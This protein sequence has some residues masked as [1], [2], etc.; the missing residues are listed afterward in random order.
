MTISIYERPHCIRD[1]KSN[2]LGFFLFSG[3][4]ISGQE[5]R[6]PEFFKCLKYEKKRCNFTLRWLLDL[7]NTSLEQNLRLKTLGCLLFIPV[8]FL[9]YCLAAPW[10]TFG[11]YQAN[12]LI[13][14]IL[15]TAF[16]L[17]VFSPELELES[18]LVLY[19]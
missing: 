17:S 11:C 12:S 5:F 1:R 9:I 2:T 13:H 16:G 3:C 14:P 8:I 10:S 7:G 18:G 19:T 4:W 15:I 6:I